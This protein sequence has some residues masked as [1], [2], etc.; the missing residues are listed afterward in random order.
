[1]VRPNACASAAPPVLVG[2][3]F[4][5]SIA[6]EKAA[7]S[8]AGTASAECAC[9]AARIQHER[10]RSKSE[11]V[12]PRGVVV[13]GRGAGWWG[14][15]LMGQRRA[16]G[17]RPEKRL[18]Q[19]PPQDSDPIEKTCGPPNGLAFSCRERAQRSRQN[20]HDL[21]RE[22]VS[23]NA[24]LGRFGISKIVFCGIGKRYAS[25]CV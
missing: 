12:W 13:G 20:S 8:V 11:V 3:T 2:N 6:H 4:K 10:R 25:D 17:A 1:M 24:G 9:W 7:I 23:C 18:R 5:S 22:A 21:A 19:T 16:W 14:R 15:W